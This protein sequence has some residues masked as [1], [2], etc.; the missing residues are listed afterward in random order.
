LAVARQRD[1][2]RSLVVAE[3]RND[4]RLERPFRGHELDLR[5]L[6]GSEPGDGHFDRLVRVEGV[7]ALR[8]DEFRTACRNK[9]CGEHA[10]STDESG[11]AGSVHEV[12]PHLKTGKPLHPNPPGFTTGGCARC[13]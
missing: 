9:K 10:S 12:Y 7:S 2:D 8:E 11:Q 4:D 6:G 3:H 5:L 13:R 1:H